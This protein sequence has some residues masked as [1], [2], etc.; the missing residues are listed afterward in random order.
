MKK[1]IAVC[2]A[3]ALGLIVETTALAGEHAAIGP[4]KCKMCHKVQYAS[5]EASKHPAKNVD[6][7]A[8]HGNG[9]DYWM[10]SVMKDRAKA[11]AAGLVMPTVAQC[12]KCH[13]NADAALLPKAHAHKGG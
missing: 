6:C 7:E 10:A 3:A 9:G 5:W 2:A 1:L 11:T 8:C 13:P 12:K 4:E